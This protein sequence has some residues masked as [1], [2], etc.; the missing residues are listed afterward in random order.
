MSKGNKRWVLLTDVVGSRKI[1]DRT[2][3]EKVFVQAIAEANRVFEAD[4]ILP[5]KGW[6]GLDEQAAMIGDPKCLYRL[7]DFLNGMMAPVQLRLSIVRH[8][9]DVLPADGD[10][11]SADGPAFH[12]AAAQMLQLKEKGLLFGILS[13]DGEKD[14]PL[15]VSINL[16]LLQKEGWTR[17]QRDI[18]TAYCQT[19]NQEAVAKKLSV[20]QQAISKALKTIKGSQVQL[21]EDSLQQWLDKQYR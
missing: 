12:E 16:L 14:E 10:I 20:S 3:F 15:A 7:A 13:G 11:R 18:Y 2:A 1:K 5:V 21:L 19:G 17:R 8:E 4:L 9:V 6:K